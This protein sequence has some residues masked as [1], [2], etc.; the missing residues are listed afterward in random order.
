MKAVVSL[1]LSFSDLTGQIS[2]PIGSLAK[3]QVRDLS[4]NNLTGAIPAALDRLHF[5][6]AFNISNNDLEGPIP[7]GGQFNTFPTA[8]FDGNTK[9]CG[10]ILSCSCDLA[11]AP[12]TTILTTEE[13]TVFAISFSAFFCIGVMYDQIFLSK[14]FP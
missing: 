13:K 6:S 1:N 8:S 2:E 7:S 11:E 3:L 10:P 12:P 9:L 4:R 14:F 5:L